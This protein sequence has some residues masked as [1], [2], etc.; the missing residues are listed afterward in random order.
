MLFNID[1]K[2]LYFPVDNLGKLLPYENSF[3]IFRLSLQ[4][5]Y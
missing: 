5:I 3:K 4:K 2:L 1:F